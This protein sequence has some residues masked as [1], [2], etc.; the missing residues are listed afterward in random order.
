MARFRP[1]FVIV[2]HEHIS[3]EAAFIGRAIRLGDD[4][5]LQLIDATMR[6]RMVAFQQAALPERPEILR[7]IVE[8]S[9]QSFGVYANPLLAGSVTIGD[10]VIL[11]D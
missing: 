6:C 9:N 8:N 7:H 2:L 1:N 10:K 11:L 4:V 3:L 5:E